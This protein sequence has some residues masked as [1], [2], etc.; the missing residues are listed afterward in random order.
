ML[1]LRTALLACTTKIIRS[2]TQTTMPSEIVATLY[3]DGSF[4]ITAPIPS[5]PFATRKSALISKKRATKNVAKPEN[6]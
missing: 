3:S 4:L 6:I 2:T 5:I 1:A